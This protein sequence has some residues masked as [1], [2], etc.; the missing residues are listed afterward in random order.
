MSNPVC[1]HKSNYDNVDRLVDAGTWV[2][3]DADAM[4]LDGGW[5]LV[6]FSVCQHMSGDG[7]PLQGASVWALYRRPK[8]LT[9]RG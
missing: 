3:Y 7:T 5:E 9:P 1:E 4:S 8:Q 2:M 6:S